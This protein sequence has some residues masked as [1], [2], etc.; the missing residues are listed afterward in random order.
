MSR[1]SAPGRRGWTAV[2]VL[3][4]LVALAAALAWWFLLRE[5]PV[6]RGPPIRVATGTVPERELVLMES[7]PGEARV[8]FLKRVG[9]VLTD[10]A[11]LTG[12]EACGQ[13]CQNHDSSG[14]AV[15]VVTNDAHIMCAMW[16][17]CPTGYIATGTNIH[18]HCPRARMLRANAADAA[19]SGNRY[20][21]GKILPPCDP[22]RFSLQDFAGGPGY[23]ATPERLLLQSGKDAISDLGV[24]APADAALT[25]LDP[26][27]YNS[28]SLPQ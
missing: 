5:E 24:L 4:V 13:V 10:H 26:A 15:Q 23:L 12:H 16:T 17:T 11:E 7:A 8:D 18:A 25:L 28:A 21:R 14:F 22:E 1:A 27:T 9:R 20:R 3:L 19:F 2:A 6:W